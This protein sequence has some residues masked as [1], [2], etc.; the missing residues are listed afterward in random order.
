M[1]VYFQIMYWNPLFV[2][3]VVVLVA[4]EASNWPVKEPKF[5]SSGDLDDEWEAFKIKYGNGFSYS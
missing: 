3:F 4:A 5:Y 2:C 1:S